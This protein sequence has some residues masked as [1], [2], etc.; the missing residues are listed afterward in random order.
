MNRP[1][2]RTAM[3]TYE[4]ARLQRWAAGRSV[5][6]CGSL[7]GYSTVLM[8]QVARSVV[9][10]DRHDGYPSLGLPNDT[11]RLMLG[12]LHRYNVASKVTVVVGEHRQVAEWPSDLA[13]IDLDGTSGTTLDAVR[14][15]QAPFVAIH[16]YG[17]HA[18]RGVAHAVAALVAA[19]SHRVIERADTLV[20][21]RSLKR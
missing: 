14:R 3:S 13:F 21:L 12:N 10:I 8:A 1:S 5:V 2:I 16:D 20:V 19:G 7:L 15:A 17:R 6:E 18:C 11:L 4:S 9:S